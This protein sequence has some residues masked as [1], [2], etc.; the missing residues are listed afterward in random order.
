MRLSTLSIPELVEACRT[1]PRVAKVCEDDEVTGVPFW[2]NRL[3]KTYG[4]SKPSAMRRETWKNVVLI[5]STLK[6][7]RPYRVW[8]YVAEKHRELEQPDFS[9]DY[10]AIFSDGDYYMQGRGGPRSGTFYLEGIPSPNIW[11]HEK[12]N[13]H[14]KKFVDVNDPEL[15]IVK[16][17]SYYNIGLEFFNEDDFFIE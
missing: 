17:G 16:I 15:A 6:N 10:F 7:P 9:D 8:P 2:E 5:L 14:I 13:A 4:R 12:E 11:V 3:E 1:D